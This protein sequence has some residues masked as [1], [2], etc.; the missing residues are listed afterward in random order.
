[1]MKKIYKMML[2]YQKMLNT[3][4]IFKSMISNKNNLIILEQ[5]KEN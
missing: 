4:K 2:Y 1:M 3:K 5:N